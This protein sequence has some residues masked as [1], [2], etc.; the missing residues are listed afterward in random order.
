MY[1]DAHIWQ[2]DVVK[3]DLHGAHEAGGG[4]PSGL[5]QRRAQH[6]RDGDAAVAVEHLRPARV[7]IMGRP[8]QLCQADRSC[9]RVMC[10][11]SAPG[12]SPS[13]EVDDLLGSCCVL[14]LAM[15]ARAWCHMVRGW[16]VQ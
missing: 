6:Q 16:G 5:G 11:H 15:L 2:W 12:R 13:G 9:L 1:S 3:G 4:E 8:G 7:V 14:L 10:C